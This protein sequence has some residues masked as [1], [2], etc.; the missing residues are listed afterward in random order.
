[1]KAE[2]LAETESHLASRSEIWTEAV[3]VETEYCKKK[4][5]EARAKMRSVEKGTKKEVSV[6]RREMVRIRKRKRTAA[7][8]RETK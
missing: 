3:A 4:R 2:I 5:T 6:K 7:D 8:W 1:M